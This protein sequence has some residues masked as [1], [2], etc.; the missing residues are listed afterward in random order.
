MAF[1]VGQKVH[2]RRANN[3]LGTYFPCQIIALTSRHDV[4]LTHPF[5]EWNVL[6]RS[7]C[8]FVSAGLL[9]KRIHFYDVMYDE[10]GQTEE[11]VPEGRVR[12]HAQ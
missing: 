1:E 4:S 5:A 3:A 8:H 11:Q 6:F 9:C 7:V 10:D 2:A 12:L